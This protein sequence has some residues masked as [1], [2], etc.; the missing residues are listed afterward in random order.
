MKLKTGYYDGAQPRSHVLKVLRTHG[1]KVDRL[2]TDQ[3]LMEDLDGYPEVVFLPDP[4]LSEQIVHIFRRFG[5]LHD[6]LITDLRD[7]NSRP[8]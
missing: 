7:P 3:Y 1:V 6:F 8:N 4:V 5:G 2:A